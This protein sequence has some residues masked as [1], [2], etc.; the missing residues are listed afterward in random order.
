[1]TDS[2]RDVGGVESGP[3]LE[4]RGVDTGDLRITLGR[5]PTASPRVA[6]QTRPVRFRLA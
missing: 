6:A 1:M 4:A 2:T 3:P 5:R